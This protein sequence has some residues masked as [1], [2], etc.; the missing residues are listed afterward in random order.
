MPAE[1]IGL[2]EN[3]A[4]IPKDVDLESLAMAWLASASPAANRLAAAIESVAWAQA[5]PDWRTD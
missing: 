3:L 1:T 4:G 2:V 5:L